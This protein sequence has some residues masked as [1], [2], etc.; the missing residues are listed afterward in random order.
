M[1]QCDLAIRPPQAPLKRVSPAS[2]LPITGQIAYALAPMIARGVMLGP[3][4]PIILHLLDVEQAQQALDGVRMELMDAALP[5]LRGWHPS[6][7]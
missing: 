4:Q 7:L 3:K 6:P 5:L 2:L 1:R